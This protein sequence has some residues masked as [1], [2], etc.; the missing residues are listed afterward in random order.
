MMIM[1]RKHVFRAEPGF[2]EFTFLYTMY[3]L[4]E[5]FF[6]K[7]IGAAVACSLLPDVVICLCIYLVVTKM[8]QTRAAS[9]F[10]RL[11]R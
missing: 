4:G 1:S 2:F 9:F 7:I 6:Q 11:C 10:V 8:K 3:Y 5:M